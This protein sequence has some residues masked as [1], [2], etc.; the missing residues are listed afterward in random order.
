MKKILTVLAVAALVAFAAPA[1]AANPFMDVPAGHWA[2]DA[3]AQLAASGVVSGYPDGAFKG[4]QPATRYEVASV[5]ARALAKVDLEK[6]SKQ[7]LEMLKKLVM[8]FKDELDALGVKVDK[9]DKRVAVLEDRIGGWKITGEFRHDWKFADVD[10]GAY[11]DDKQ[12]NMNRARLHFYKFIDENTTFYGRLNSM[13]ATW[14]R[15]QITTKLPYDIEFRAGRFNF[16]WEGDMNYY[17]PDDI[18]NDATFG[19]Y[20][21]TGFQFKKTWG[22]F[23]ATAVVGRDSDLETYA[24]D[25]GNNSGIDTLAGTDV[26]VDADNSYMLYALK[27]HADFNEKFRGGLMGYWLHGD[28]DVNVEIGSDTYTLDAPNIYTY[29]VYAGFDFTPSVTLQ[30]IYYWQSIDMPAGTSSTPW[31]KEDNPKS[32]KA[33]LL[34]KQDLLKFTSLWIEYAQEDNM[35]LG[36]N[37]FGVTYDWIGANPTANKIFAAIYNPAGTTKTFFVRADQKWNDKW[38]TFLRYAQFDFDTDEVD[39]TKNWSVGIN[40]QYTPAINFRL[41]YDYIDY[42]DS[43]YTCYTDD[44]HV[45]SFRTTVNF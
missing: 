10:G 24:E 44:D 41:A 5:V 11:G 20:D 13:D 1:F 42:G 25:A 7:D 34:V 19:D 37:L 31:G 9:L 4:G 22:M 32:W 45:I 8:E 38:S 33:Q 2:Y 35:F 21:V 27:L 17:N 18:N 36:N 6:A 3:V 30:G 28:R 23:T 29:G 39:D 40:Y 16:D 12:S 14:A 15:Y 26:S 43:S